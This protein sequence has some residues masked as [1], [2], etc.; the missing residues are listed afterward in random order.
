MREDVKRIS[1]IVLANMTT[2][3]KV[4]GNYVLNLAKNYLRKQEE[5][6][7]VLA[8][9]NAA[10]T[11]ANTQKELCL[12]LS[13]L[14]V[15]IFNGLKGYDLDSLSAT[16]MRSMGMR[17]NIF[18]YGI[19]KT[20]LNNKLNKPQTRHLQGLISLALITERQ[21]AMNFFGIYF[22]NYFP[23]LAYKTPNIIQLQDT[24]VEYVIEV[25]LI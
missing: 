1:E 24:G 12:E 11:K 18:L 15:N 8:E 17:G 5:E 19:P 25:E 6:N 9:R 14:S 16:H 20:C 10:I 13:S 4:V 21:N 2:A 7:K 23:I 22:P 3:G